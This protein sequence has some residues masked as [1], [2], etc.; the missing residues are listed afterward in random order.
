MV[1]HFGRNPRVLKCL[2][3][4]VSYVLNKHL[5]MNVIKFSVP[6][7]PRY[8]KCINYIPCNAVVCGS[9]LLEGILHMP[10]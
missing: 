10:V 4:L 3:L 8:L 1:I 2:N 6:P 5:R 7:L 9:T